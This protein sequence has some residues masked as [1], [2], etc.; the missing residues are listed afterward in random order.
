MKR[1]ALAVLA[2]AGLTASVARADH[3]SRVTVRGSVTIGAPVYSA[4]VP[5]YA[6]A[7][8][9]A[10]TPVYTA[11]ARGYWKDVTV[12]TWVPERW[13]MTRNHWGRPVRVFEPGYFAY[14]TDRVWVDTSHRGYGY[15][16]HRDHDNRGHGYAYGRR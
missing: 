16:D 11:P 7:P 14:R 6:P 13:V 2:A 15:N 4:P 9:Y 1:I 3:D 8:V 10:P 5:V 12:K